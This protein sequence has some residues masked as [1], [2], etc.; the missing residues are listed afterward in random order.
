M[1]KKKKRERALERE[2]KKK[3]AL[4]CVAQL[5]STAQR[6]VEVQTGLSNTN[7]RK[8]PKRRKK[9]KN[10]TRHIFEVHVHF[11]FLLSFSFPPKHV[12]AHRRKK[13]NH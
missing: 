7:R 3:T 8:V 13:K 9:R 12:A 2:R 4:L 5:S 6:F 10:Y 11:L 1:K